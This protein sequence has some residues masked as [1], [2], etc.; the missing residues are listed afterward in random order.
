MTDWDSWQKT[1]NHTVRTQ[2]RWY[3][4]GDANG[5]PLFT[6]PM[7]SEHDTPEQWMDAADLQMTFPARDQ[8]GRPNRVTEL[9]LT[10]A[11]EH[12][13]PSGQ[14]P[15]AEGDYMLLVA[16]PGKNGTVVRRGG[17]IVHAVGNDPTNDGTPSEIT[18]NALNL[19]DVW[20]TV[21]AVSWPAAWWKAE[22]YET[23]SDE[24]G[25]EYKK[26]RYMARVELATR[27][28]FVWKNGPAAFVIRRLA[29]ESL[30]AT[31]RTQADPDGTKW[32][33]DP[34]HVVEVPE[35]DTSA[36]ISLEARD[37]FL[38]ETVSKQA[39]NAGV[40][41]GAYL[42]WPGDAPVRC[43]N[44]ATSDMAPRDVDITPSQGESSRTL[45]YRSFEHAMTVMTVKEV[46]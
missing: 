43:W 12:F 24:S 16:F 32:V 8:Y 44:Q 35:L 33:D 36:E 5:A 6:L 38:W 27:P 21:P 23:E 15:T 39:E 29:Q 19:M 18:I 37:G 22:P 45:S 30:D 40:I 11:I 17:A 25:L 28:M 34:Y 26:P 13:D 3:G 1:V 2:G 4:I 9:L 42:W 14:L 7:P 46:A 31:M 10:S 41:L 20:H